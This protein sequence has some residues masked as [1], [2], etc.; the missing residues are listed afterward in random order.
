MKKKQTSKYLKTNDLV[1]I[2]ILLLLHT[3]KVSNYI[4][5][6]RKA[7]EIVCV[8]KCPTS[9]ITTGLNENLSAHGISFNYSIIK[10]II[11]IYVGICNEEE[12]KT[13][14]F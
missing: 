10:K 9:V 14:V 7:K 4:S 6:L 1:K 13:K 11:Y 2:Y 5:I 8:I 3:F 12:K